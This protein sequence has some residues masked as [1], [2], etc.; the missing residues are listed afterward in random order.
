MSRF[1]VV[2]GSFITRN[3]ITEEPILVSE[4]SKDMYVVTFARSCRLAL[5]A[6]ALKNQHDALTL[7]DIR[8]KTDAAE[9]GDVLELTDDQWKVLEPEF[10]RPTNSNLM[11][12][13]WMFSSETHQRAILDAK[14]EAPKADAKTEVRDAKQVRKFA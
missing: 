3:P 10:K 13:A 11:D 2:P 9:P 14:T 5:T 8:R 4:T 1:I 12:T 7:L 6:I